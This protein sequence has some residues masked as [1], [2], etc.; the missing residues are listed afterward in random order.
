MRLVVAAFRDAHPSPAFCEFL[1]KIRPIMT[2]T[3]EE[4][5]LEAAQFLRENFLTNERMDAEEI[6]SFAAEVITWPFAPIRPVGEWLG[7]FFLENA[8]S[9]VPTLRLGRACILIRVFCECEEK[10]DCPFE[11]HSAPFEHMACDPIDDSHTQFRINP[12]FRG[13]DDRR[14]LI[15]LGPYLDRESWSYELVRKDDIA[16]V[17]PTEAEP[18]HPSLIFV[19]NE[20]A[21]NKLMWF[22]D[23]NSETS[24]AVPELLRFLPTDPRFVIESTN[25]SSFIEDWL[26]GYVQ[27]PCMLGYLVRV[28]AWRSQCPVYAA[29]YG[30]Y[31]DQV[32]DICLPIIGTFDDA[33]CELVLRCDIPFSQ[34]LMAFFMTQLRT[35]P[36]LAL[37]EAVTR[38][39]IPHTVDLLRV[40]LEVL[41]RD[42]VPQDSLDSLLAFLAT[43]QWETEN[44]LLESVRSALDAIARK[45][46]GKRFQ[47]FVGSLFGNNVAR[48]L[49]QLAGRLPEPKVWT[50][51][52]IRHEIEQNAGKLSLFLSRIPPGFE[53]EFLAYTK[54]LPPNRQRELAQQAVSGLVTLL[55]RRLIHEFTESVIG[56]FTEFPSESSADWLVTSLTEGFPSDD[57][58]DHICETLV[59]CLRASDPVTARAKIGSIVFKF[60]RQIL[61]VLELQTPPSEDQL[62]LPCGIRNLGSTCYISCSLQVLLHIPAFEY[63]IMASDSESSRLLDHL[64]RCSHFLRFSRRRE[65]PIKDFCEFLKLDM[66]EQ[67]DA[68]WFIDSVL[69][70]ELSRLSPSSVNLFWHRMQIRRVGMDGNEAVDDEQNLFVRL[71][72]KGFPDLPSSLE[73][74]MSEQILDGTRRTQHFSHLPEV[75][76]FQFR[77]S[78]IDHGLPVKIT[79]RFEFPDSVSLA[80]YCLGR[81]RADYKLFAVIFHESF[82]I[83]GVTCEDRDTGHYNCAIRITD[84]WFHFNDQIVSEISDG[85]MRHLAFGGPRSYSSAYLVFYA[86]SGSGALDS[87][88][89]IPVQPRLHQEVI[90]DNR[91]FGIECCAV[92]RSTIGLVCECARFEEEV[93]RREPLERLYNLN[94]TY[95]SRG[96]RVNFESRQPPPSPELQQLQLLLESFPSNEGE[97][98][99]RLPPRQTWGEMASDATDL[100]IPQARERL[101]R[102]TPPA[103]WSAY[104]TGMPTATRDRRETAESD[105]RVAGTWPWK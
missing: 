17:T 35:S 83:P 69:L 105:F 2:Q 84:R 81:A 27:Q 52:A 49:A 100:T 72:V 65:C 103:F 70:A 89:E 87:G 23:R 21:M 37:M 57:T 55:S 30:E 79:D 74:E 67:Q 22:A 5:A 40:I 29:G 10:G 3:N 13:L 11:R 31:M 94:K 26:P 38:L 101:E 56:S 90:D 6:K 54:T 93:V 86:Q 14:L 25:I 48:S 92:H 97:R 50:M 18:G 39:P 61:A 41:E 8:N 71:T 24:D 4:L 85:R 7:R 47:H 9:E 34:Q 45:A 16:I 66:H 64:Q 78:A 53:D 62:S 33:I 1:A 96:R 76:M 73:H 104:Q 12:E 88:I 80:P 46:D 58:R 51:E 44:G 42:A 43:V 91:K 98:R 75:L 102:F 82:E 99:G 59:R 15:A 60:V 36:D 32:L 19:R 68:A 63:F 95:R 28:I 77:R 20:Q